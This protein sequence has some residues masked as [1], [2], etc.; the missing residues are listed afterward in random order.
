MLSD[1]IYY[2]RTREGENLSITQRRN[3]PEELDNRLL[4][5]QDVSEYLA[6][7][8]PR[9]AKRWYA[10]VVE[11]QVLNALDTADDDYRAYFIER[12]NAYC[13]GEPPRVP[14]LPAIDR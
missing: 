2:W 1:V 11:P 5:I 12:V 8:R 3:H 4:A 10:T 9:K 14:A 7:H 6:E 13:E